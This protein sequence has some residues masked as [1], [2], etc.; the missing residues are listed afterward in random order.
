M[1]PDTIAL[2]TYDAMRALPP[3]AML[4]N[5][6]LAAETMAQRDALLKT[7][8]P[9]VRDAAMRYLAEPI[10]TRERTRRL[11]WMRQ[12]PRR[13]AALKV[14]YR[15]HIADFVCDYGTTYDPRLI[16]DGRSPLI[17]FVLFPKQRELVQFIIDRMK[18]KQ[19]GTV[20]KGR[21]VGATATCVATLISLCLL[22]GNFA[23]GVGSST[24][25]KLDR[26][27]VPDSVFAHAD[28][29]L[30]GVPDEFKGEVTRLYLRINFGNGSSF[31]GEAGNQCG[32]G[33]RKAAY[34]MD[35]YAFHPF[36]V[37]VDAA[38]SQ[39]TNTVLWISTFNGPAGPFYDKSLNPAIPRFD[40]TWRDRPDR[41][42]AWYN[43][44]KSRT[45]PVIF[46]QEVDAN[47]LASREGTIIPAEWIHAAIDL[48][49]KLKIEPTGK[50]FA[51]LDVA[52][53]GRDSNSLAARHGI[54]LTDV[55]S[56]SGKNSD[57]HATTQHA[58]NILDE[59]GL[60]ELGSLGFDGL[61]VDFDGI[62]SG[63]KGAARIINEQRQD[64]QLSTIHMRGYRGSEAPVHPDRKVPG[65]D[66]GGK[67][68]RP[69]ARHSR[70][71]RCGYDS[72]SPTGPPTGFRMTRM[73]S[74]PLIQT[75]RT[76]RDLSHS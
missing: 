26:S 10:E 2:A 32:R 30:A 74:C 62:G 53:A 42:E 46:A 7:A 21:D 56:W 60:P 66:R 1:T 31:V 41:D 24:E 43:D 76:C 23:A 65:T 16:A 58:F 67:T 64:N 13:V 12:D 37:S 17:P 18:G 29:F 14:Y 38:L 33:G 15:G 19:H 8:T 3:F 73:K 25:D 59:H 69:T 49:T 5:S 52:D 45:D 50:H 11:E 72:N 40:I 4:A 75:L 27:G 35:E 34:L 22:E 44:V 68:S 6:L 39:N 9:K 57:L 61:S 36:P 63:C 70:G 51:G 47:P 48:H 54:L 55:R 20:C 71:G 28:H